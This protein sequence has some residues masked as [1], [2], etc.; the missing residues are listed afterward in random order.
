MHF[1]DPEGDGSD[2]NSECPPIST[3]HVQSTRSK[4]SM[5]LS[6]PHSNPIRF[7]NIA[8]PF[9]VEGTEARRSQGTLVYG[10]QQSCFIQKAF[11]GYK[12]FNVKIWDGLG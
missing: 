7:H 1:Q 2:G 11:L 5:Q 12:I 6:H 8:I 10:D 3:L 4:Y 9:T